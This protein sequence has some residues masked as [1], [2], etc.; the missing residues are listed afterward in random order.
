MR[1]S[2]ELADKSVSGK[3]RGYHVGNNVIQDSSSMQLGSSIW[4][5]ATGLHHNAVMYDWGVIVASLLR[6]LSDKQYRVGGMYFEF[7]NSGSDVDPVPEFTRDE[8]VSYYLGLSGTSDFLRVPLTA[9]AGAQSDE[10]NFSGNNVAT[11]FAQTAGST[12]QR[13]ASP[14]TFSDASS[15]RVYGGAL[16]AF[17]QYS[18]ITQDLILSRFYFEPGDQV[19]KVASSQIGLTWA[20]TLN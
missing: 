7:D 6:G 13:S 18:D 12:G 1:H 3:V 11:F 10:D 9:T 8:T 2:D 4:T 17:R 15:S 20:I 5:P 16:V 14:L 19:E